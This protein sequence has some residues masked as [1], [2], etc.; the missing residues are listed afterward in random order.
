[1][2]KFA[3]IFEIRRAV[4]T[5]TTTQIETA[6]F[7]WKTIWRVIAQLW[8]EEPS[9]ELGLTTARQAQGAFGPMVQ[10]FVVVALQTEGQ[11]ALVRLFEV[12]AT[13]ADELEAA[14]KEGQRTDREGFKRF[15][16]EH[17]C[18]LADDGNSLARI[19]ERN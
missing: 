18:S 6:Q 16:D 14:R 12:L 2:R 17:P 11:K 10:S 1:M 9:C 15:L 19:L 7:I 3:N 13:Y 5:A 4:Q 8:P